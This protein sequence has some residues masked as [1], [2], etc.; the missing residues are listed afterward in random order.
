MPD[1]KEGQ[2][3]VT[4]EGCWSQ[5]SKFFFLKMFKWKDTYHFDALEGGRKRHGCL[6]YSG[7]HSGNGRIQSILLS[8]S[9]FLPINLNQFTVI[10]TEYENTKMPPT[11]YKVHPKLSIYRLL[12]PQG[13]ETQKKRKQKK[14]KI[15]AAYS[16]L[17]P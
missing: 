5:S 4:C 10:T 1:D 16:S 11:P 8:G 14:N 9:R 2:G 13:C 15:T 12:N 6:E 3:G 7:A 17:W